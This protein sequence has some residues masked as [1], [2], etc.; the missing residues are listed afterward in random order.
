MEISQPQW[1]RGYYFSLK[2]GYD[3]DEVEVLFKEMELRGASIQRLL[4]AEQAIEIF[5]PEHQH[6]DIYLNSLAACSSVDKVIS[7]SSTTTKLSPKVRR[8]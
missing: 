8:K 1:G 7:W 6:Q 2:E 3:E 5:I 4:N